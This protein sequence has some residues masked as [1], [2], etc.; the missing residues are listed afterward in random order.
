MRS[1]VNAPPLLSDD[2][3]ERAFVDADAMRDGWSSAAALETAALRVEQDASD[4]PR[5]LVALVRLLGE[6]GLL[7]LTVPG[8]YGGTYPDVRSVPLCLARERLGYASPLVELAFAMQALGSYP[9]TARGSDHL[10]ELYLP[11]VA[12]GE[13]VAAFALTEEDAGSDLSRM[14]TSATLVSDGYL[15]RGKKIFISNAGVASFYVVF[16]VTTPATAETKLRLSAFVVDAG[17]PGVS[18]RPQQVLGGHPIGELSLADVLVPVSSRVGPEGAGMSIALE[19]LHK[20]RPTVGAA[21]LG[22]GQRALSETLAH[23][24]SREQFGAPLAELQA[25]QMAIADMACE[26]EASRLLVYRAAAVADVTAQ[27]KAQNG[28]AHAGERARVAQ[29]GSMAKLVATESAF[30]V[31]D[32]AV[33]LHGGRGVETSSIVARLYT[34]V[35]ALRIYEGA[36]PVQRRLIARAPLERGV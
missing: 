17:Q 23:V 29:T 31:I 30:R 32:R 28:T 25:V 5:A 26:L 33:Q 22:M 1:T 3:V 36:A 14:R 20:L 11:R 4:A 9:I 7:G 10:R 12:A 16:A 21:A 24:R 19:T 18:T 8:A 2:V 13:A 34:D 27:L 35:R 15:L 6:R